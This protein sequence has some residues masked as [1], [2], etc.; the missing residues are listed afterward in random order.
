LAIEGK[1]DQLNPYNYYLNQF[2]RATINPKQGDATTLRYY[3]PNLLNRMAP[4]E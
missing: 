3:A 2:F 1:T 4:D